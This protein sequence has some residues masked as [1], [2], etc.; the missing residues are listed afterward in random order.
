[1]SFMLF[2]WCISCVLC[3]C[4]GISGPEIMSKLAGESESNLRKAF[5][6]AE[7]NAPA[8]IFIDELDAIAPKR[9][10]VRRRGKETGML[11]NCVQS[12]VRHWFDGYV[13]FV[14]SRWGWA[15]DRLSAAHPDG[16]PETTRSCCGHGSHK[17][18]QQCGSRSS[19][20][21]CE[22]T[23]TC[24]YKGHLSVHQ[25][26]NGPKSVVSVASAPLCRSFWSRD[27]HWHPWFHRPAGDFTDSHQEHETIRRCGPG[28]GENRRLK[29]CL[30]H[31]RCFITV[32]LFMVDRHWNTRACGSR[33]GRS[34]FRGS[35]AG[36]PQKDDLNR[37]GG[38]QHRR[39]P[40]QLTGRHH[41][42]LQGQHSHLD[43]IFCT[44]GH[45]LPRLHSFIDP[46]IMERLMLYSS[47]KFVSDISVR[48]K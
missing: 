25:Q 23:H 11:S 24:T 42:W 30:I 19:A 21:W 4:F 44:R 5:E 8:I 43:T 12:D 16:R 31:V 9:E 29:E 38:R 1:M 13:T 46:E 26:M 20:L 17:Q 45:L 48:E 33:Y 34:V 7:K 3:C 10:K 39:R 22:H 40:S 47:I 2:R 14:D 35:A 18:T 36:H 27:W 41:G 15:E 28:A 32:F 37:F 6:E